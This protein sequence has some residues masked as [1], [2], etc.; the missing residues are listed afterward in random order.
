[1]VVGQEAPQPARALRAVGKRQPAQLRPA[2]IHQGGDVKALV[3]V[4]A[5]EHG[6]LRLG[7]V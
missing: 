6:D 2:R 4:D 3:R 7:S 5:H 1:V